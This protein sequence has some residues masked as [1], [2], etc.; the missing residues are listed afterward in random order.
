MGCSYRL[1][2]VS[3]LKALPSVPYILVLGGL[4]NKQI[5]AKLERTYHTISDVRR[6]PA[7]AFETHG[8]RELFAECLRRGRRRLASPRLAYTRDAGGGAFSPWCSAHGVA[9]ILDRP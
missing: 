6:R 1:A 9:S 4:D 5:A 7:R 3:R 8:D 2:S